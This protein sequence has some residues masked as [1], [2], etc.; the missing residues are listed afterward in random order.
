MR[1]IPYKYTLHHSQEPLLKMGISLTMQKSLEVL[2]MPVLDLYSWLQEEVE[3]NPFLEW[4]YT[5]PLFHSNPLENQDIADKPSLFEHL[6]QQAHLSFK[7]PLLLKIATWIIGNVEPTGFFSCSLAESP[8]LSYPSQW[9]ECLRVIQQFDPPGVGAKNLQESLLLQ[10]KFLGKTDS[11]AAKILEKDSPLLIAQDFIALQKKY[12]L[13]S[14]ELSKTL[15]DLSSLDAFP[16]HHFL[17]EDRPSPTVDIIVDIEEGSYNLEIVQP[18]P[19]IQEIDLNCC[20]IEEKKICKQQQMRAHQVLSSLSKRADTLYKVANYLILKQKSYLLQETDSLCSIN[21]RGLA[22]R[23]GVHES[24]V[25]RALAN[26]HISCPRGILPLKSLLS[27]S[28]GENSSSD[29][30]QKLLKKWILEENKKAPLSDRE[31]LEKMQGMGIS[32]ARRTITKYRKLL[33]IPSSRDRLKK[34]T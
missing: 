8:F 16:G 25:T 15:K 2:Q 11:I 33:D 30:A 13:S 1:D 4:E 34:P 26:K 10:L 9:Q 19:T 5:H 18:N 27:S 32:C 14:E 21:A 24:T 28:L 12:H 23:L 7:D 22:N 17:Q 20:S 31:L 6:M 29:E 3:Q